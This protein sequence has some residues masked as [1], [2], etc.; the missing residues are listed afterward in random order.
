MIGRIRSRRTPLRHCTRSTLAIISGALLCAVAACASSAPPRAAPSNR[1]STPPSAPAASPSLPLTGTLIA[2]QGHGGPSSSGV[3]G[4][5]NVVVSPGASELC[6][7]IVASG[8]HQPTHAEVVSRSDPT[9]SF[10]LGTPSGSGRSSGCATAPAGVVDALA[11]RPGDFRVV[12]DEA[13]YPAGAATA[14]LAADKSL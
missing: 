2:A 12:I 6:W 3:T 5:V 13:S 11:Q 10:V 9:A 7:V 14:D 1:Q 4:V 8:I